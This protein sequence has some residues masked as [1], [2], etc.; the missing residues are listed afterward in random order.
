MQT[1]TS[2]NP[3]VF[4]VKE[5]EIVLIMLFKITTIILTEEEHITEDRIP[6]CCKNPKDNLTAV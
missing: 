2:E 6:H 3:H 5:T 1:S 4:P